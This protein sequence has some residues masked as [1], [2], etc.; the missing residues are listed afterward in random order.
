MGQSVSA[1]DKHKPLIIQR[2][3]EPTISRRFIKDRIVSIELEDNFWT[4]PRAEEVE[5]KDKRSGQVLFRLPPQDGNPATKHE[6]HQLLDAFRVPVVGL[7]WTN[8]KPTLAQYVITP[9][10]ANPNNDVLYE[11]ETQINPFFYPLELVVNKESPDACVKLYVIGRWLARRTVVGIRRGE[12][13]NIYKIAEFNAVG[14]VTNP[15]YRVDI[16]PGVDIALMLMFAAAMDEQSRL[17]ETGSD[18]TALRSEIKREQRL[19][20]QRAQQ[21]QQLPQE[22][23]LTVGAIAAEPRSTATTIT[24]V[25]ISSK[26]SSS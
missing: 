7:E 21:Q 2:Q 26:P 13:G 16:A 14:S 1:D 4:K 8:Q 5:I 9:G 23:P 3:F 12:E 25:P 24:S 18:R 15:F 10:G 19:L 22:P 11:F 17:H 6:R 20:R